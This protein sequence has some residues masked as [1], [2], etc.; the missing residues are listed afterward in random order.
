MYDPMSKIKNKPLTKSLDPLF[1]EEWSKQLEDCFL[2]CFFLSI[3]AIWATPNQ[4]KKIPKGLQVGKMYGAMSKLKKK[5]L[6][7]A[8]GAFL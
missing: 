8:L 1:W 7:R 4:P 2:C 6:T 5:P 3:V